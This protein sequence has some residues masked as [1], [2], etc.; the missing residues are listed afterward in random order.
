[1][2]EQLNLGLDVVN[3][4]IVAEETKKQRLVKFYVYFTNENTGNKYPLKFVCYERLGKILTAVF[5]VAGYKCGYNYQWKGETMCSPAQ[6]RMVF[7]RLRDETGV[8]IS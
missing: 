6:K 7:A 2:T 8:S 5:R 3:D 4:E 1:M